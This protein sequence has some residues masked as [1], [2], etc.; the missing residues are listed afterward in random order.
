MNSLSS[1]KIKE[2][3]MGKHL[4]PSIHTDGMDDDGEIIR[5]C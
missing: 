1:L 3:P 5:I 2:S 4:Y